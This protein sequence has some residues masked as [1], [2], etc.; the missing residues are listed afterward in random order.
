MYK[1]FDEAAKDHAINSSLQRS[2]YLYL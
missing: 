2:S 1:Y